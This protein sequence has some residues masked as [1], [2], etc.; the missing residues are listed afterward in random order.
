MAPHHP[1]GFPGIGTDASLKSMSRDDMAAFWKAEL[2][3][4]QRRAHRVRR[5]LDGRAQAARGE[6]VRRLE[7]GHGANRSLGAPETTKARVIVVDKPRAPQTAIRVAAI[8]AA[9]SAPDFHAIEVMN[10]ALGGLFS[11]RINMNLR[12]EHGYTY[13]AS[14]QFVFRRT[15]G[16]F[17]IGSGVRS[18]VTAPA[19]SEIFKEVRGMATKPLTGEELQMS[20]DSL[21]LA[22][23][24]NF[25]TSDSAAGTLAEIY[26][27]D[28]GLDYFSKYA[29]RTEAV[30]AEEAA[31]AAKKYVQPDELIVVAVGDRKTI[32]PALSKLNIGPVEVWDADARPEK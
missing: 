25:E 26:V 32:A 22:V 14:S 6:S 28:L 24:A 2:P 7:E 18:D 21:A 9:R 20:K 1:Y 10:M 29:E 19:V 3:A 31:A 5:H 12:E 27:Y 11:S 23:P 16:P 30:T 15:P 4:E 13:G 17:V 8:G